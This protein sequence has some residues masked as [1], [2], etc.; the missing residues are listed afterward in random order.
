MKIAVMSDSHFKSGLMEEALDFLKLEGAQYIIHA[1]D[2]CLE[3]N[4]VLLKSAGLPYVSVYGN[5]DA[6]LV[7]YAHD[8]VIHKEPY[9]FKIGELRFKLMHM[10]YYLAGHPCDVVIF[11]HT[12]IFESDFKNGTLY[13]NPGEICAREKPLSECVLLEI[14]ENEYIIN[15][16]SKRLNTQHF[17]KKEIRYDRK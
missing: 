1:G 5:N 15:Y 8:Y 6:S 12:H 3:E 11:G 4:L 2:L 7:R 9:L 17:D 10:P 13:L 14:N 16:Y